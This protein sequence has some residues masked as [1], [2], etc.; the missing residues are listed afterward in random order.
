MQKSA[1]NRHSGFLRLE[2]FDIVYLR[3]K[4]HVEK[5]LLDLDEMDK[6]VLPV[7]GR[8]KIQQAPYSIFV[9]IDGPANRPY[10]RLTSDPYLPESEIISVLLYGRTSDQ[11][12]TAD[13]ETAGSVQAAVADRAIGLFGLWIFASTPIKNFSYNPVTKVYAATIELSGDLTAE[14]GTDWE[15]TTQVEVRKRISRRW[16]LTATWT[17]ATPDEEDLTEL[18]LQ[19]EQ[20]F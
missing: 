14:I 8:L 18:V 10:V 3:R 6:G 9:D 20:R 13:A 16:A 19:W 1:D 15:E 4:V 2:P 7:D 17:P 5:L 11:L 12:A